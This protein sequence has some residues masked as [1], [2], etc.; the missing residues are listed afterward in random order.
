MI[1]DRRSSKIQTSSEIAS[2][3]PYLARVVN[4]LDP[5][6]QGSLEVEL[7]RPIGNQ[8]AAD[9]QLYVVRYLNPFYGTTNVELNGS[10]PK[11]FNHTQRSYGFWF[12]PPDT[13]TIV[14]V[15]FVDSDPGQGYW[16]GCVQDSYVN[17]MIPGLA[18]SGASQDQ[19]RVESETAWT[20]TVQHV[21]E[22]FGTTYVPVGEIN[23]KA[24]TEGNTTISAN[25]DQI[26]KPVHPMAEVLF[27][28]GTLGDNV[29]G[30]HS[31]GA[32]R[33][34]PSAV[35]GIS[36]PGPIDKR[37]NAQRGN[38]GRRDNQVNSFISRLGGHTL[39]MDD[40]NERVLRKY[41]PWEGP[42]EYVNLEENNSVEGL[43]NFP[44][45]E[46]FRIR[47][48]TGHQ[49]LLHN[50]EDVIYITNSRGTAWIEL[51]SNGKID[52]YAQDSV[53]IRTEQD[54]N[55]V[56]ERDFNVHAGR[57]INFHSG[58]AYNI[59]A[60]NDINI[61]TDTNM[62]FSA[63]NSMS[64][65]SVDKMNIN[66][67]NSMDIK[68]E[69]LKVNSASTDFLTAG[70]ILLTATG[71]L[72]LKSGGSS[73][74]SSANDTHILSASTTRLQQVSCE[75]LSSQENA[76]TS[77]TNLQIRSGTN[78]FVST[79]SGNVNLSAGN[80]TL[81]TSLGGTTHVKSSG[82]VIIKGSQ[83]HINGKDPNTAAIG[84]I[85]LNSLQAEEATSADSANAARELVL[86][87][88]PGVGQVVVKRAPT[89]EPYVHHENFN[90]PGFTPELTDREA[91]DMPFAINDE[92][93]TIR[94]TSDAD[95]VP[96]ELG[97][98]AGW[99]G[100]GRTGA[101]RGG[102]AGVMASTNPDLTTGSIGVTPTEAQLSR[103][104]TDWARDQPFLSKC[105]TLSRKYRINV[106]EI[107]A[108]I[109]FETAGTMSP[110][111]TNSLGFTG[112]IQFGNAA[113]ADMSRTYREQI[114]TGQLRQMSR[115][116]QMVWV[117]R[118]FDMWI[119]RQRVQL[120]LSIE[121]MYMLVALPAYV[122]RGPDE[123]LASA[124]GPNIRI[125]QA[126][127]GWRTE[128]RTGPITPRSIGNAPR[129]R[130]ATVRAILQRA[131]VNVNDL[132]G[133]TAPPT[134]AEQA[135]TPTS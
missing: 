65:K 73:L 46:S 22:R 60:L 21:R 105:A 117:E 133:Q 54:F 57:S 39:V 32:R 58:S 23:R 8:T 44:Q 6:R 101:G 128:N 55:F 34:A 126:N 94:R 134:P 3:G 33:E 95:Q 106:D 61:S 62:V 52:I 96:T 110:S 19:L 97:G 84:R 38:I 9:Q 18:A 29:R 24:L 79:D 80:E 78:V 64:F 90:P 120:P 47:T 81:I 77:G 14:M 5:T 125:W 82:E 88:L 122:N 7:L 107:L 98:N 63:N 28:Q 129:S 87:P 131:G 36:T 113:C 116:E 30:V 51:T 1:Q 130:I 72:E 100:G 16:M 123:I 118:Y 40:G 17:H 68:T 135:R 91:S 127:P 108:F 115:A 26:K 37:T 15:I 132:S 20:D 111:I 27:K 4:N 103:M 74:F 50:A 86:Y 10:D 119:S 25:V 75:I 67:D 53:S 114:T 85:A 11:E 35:Y 41:K 45:D 83:V 102:R 112:L 48:R 99:A 121:K 43:K 70:R 124:S 42:Y 49:I 109:Y 31:S 66:S 69:R 2:P 71:N 12:V 104:S 92:R 89:Q 76:F 59:Q 56:A 93:V 13:G